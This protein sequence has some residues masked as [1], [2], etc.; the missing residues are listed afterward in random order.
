[1]Y[2]LE[3]FISQLKIGEAQSFGRLTIKPIITGTDYSLPFLTLEEAL[4]KDVLEIIEKSDAAEVSELRVINH[5][6]ESVIIIEGEELIGAKQNRIVNATT[7]IPGK[8]E[9][10]LPVTCV[11]RG[12]W[13]HISPKF[14]SAPHGTGGVLRSVCHQSVSES[15]KESESY[16]SD[17]SAVWKEVSEKSRR[18]GFRSET[19]AASELTSEVMRSVVSMNFD[20]KFSH[21]PGQIGFIAYIDGGLAVCDIFGSADLCSKK[22]QKFARGYYTDA[23][24]HGREFPKIK[25]EDLLKEISGAILSEYP[26]VGSGRELRFE[27][28]NIRGACKVVGEEV[29]HLSVFP[30]D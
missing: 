2:K 29:S 10:I 5:G 9:I 4:E 17:Q 14:S 30:K 26:S 11:E 18:M 25:D 22:L 20:E 21:K 27:N 1:M 6:K 28:K 7:I 24:D 19:E 12:R 3:N 8:T 23:V 16:R 13:N 15:L